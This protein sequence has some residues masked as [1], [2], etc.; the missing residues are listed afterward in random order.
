M[1]ELKLPLESTAGR[2]EADSTF[3]ARLDTHPKPAAVED[4]RR[5]IWDARDLSPF[6]LPV[7]KE[8]ATKLVW[9]NPVPSKVAFFV[10]TAS[11]E[12]RI[13]GRPLDQREVGPINE[14]E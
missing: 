3:L 6:F 7:G 14:K 8:P 12:K 5:W 11:V 10:W 4:S 9:G 1:K 13:D 2:T